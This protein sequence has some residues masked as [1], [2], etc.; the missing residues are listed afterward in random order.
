MYSGASNF[1]EGVDTAFMVIIGISVLLLIA[2]T[3]VMIYFIIRYNKKR[4]PKAV[5]IHGNNWL[6]LIWT[7]IPTILVLLM[8]WYGYI[9]YVPMKQVPEDAIEITV[10]GRM[11]SW[12]FEYDN[13]RKSDK[14]IVPHNKPI[15][16]D[17]VSQDVLH[18]LYIPA[19][20]I[21]EDV[22]PGGDNF[23]WFVAQKK[24]SYDILCAE[25]CGLRH[26]Y[27]ITKLE[28]VS[29]EEYE[30]WYVLPPDSMMNQVD[31]WYDITR[32]NGCIGCHS[33]DGSKLVGSTF[34]NLYGSEQVVVVD[35]EEKT[36]TVDKP[37]LRRA[38]YDPNAEVVKGYMV[39]IMPNYTNQISEEDVE[40]IILYIKSL[41]D[42][43]GEE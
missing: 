8:F 10:T 30:E 33:T 19:F 15:K 21:K 27:M 41:S 32:A 13:G 34:K 28:V 35:G 14:L 37:Y 4:H 11:W 12:T 36:I 40:K 18:N 43:G 25:Y 39:G 5:D 1:V 3:I 26:S 17:L 2:V 38:I 7:V 22:V 23:M 29:P 16:L 6:E 42:A 20:R 9:G 24:G 31:M